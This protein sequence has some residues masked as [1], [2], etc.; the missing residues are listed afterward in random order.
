M[1]LLDNLGRP[2]VSVEDYGNGDKAYLRQDGLYDIPLDLTDDEILKIALAAHQRDI[3]M[4]QFVIEAL[5]A[6]IKEY[7]AGMADSIQ[8]S[9]DP[10]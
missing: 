2:Y 8:Q 1:E 5:E 7:E 9:D 6:H 3:T 4:N 10:S